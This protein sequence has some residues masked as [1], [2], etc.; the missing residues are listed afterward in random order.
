MARVFVTLTAASLVL[1][2]SYHFPQ[3]VPASAAE[4]KAEVRKDQGPVRF[5]PVL[6]GRTLRRMGFTWQQRKILYDALRDSSAGSEP[7]PLTRVHAIIKQA[8]TNHPTAAKILTELASR[9]WGIG[10]LKAYF[11]LAMKPADLEKLYSKVNGNLFGLAEHL[12]NAVSTRSPKA[13]TGK[14]NNLLSSFGTGQPVRLKNGQSEP[15]HLVAA[16]CLAMVLATEQCPSAGRGALALA[17]GATHQVRD[18]EARGILAELGLIDVVGNEE[19]QMHTGVM[20]VLRSCTAT[21]ESP[22]SYQSPVDRP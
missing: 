22:P 10:V 14:A 15:D 18:A 20:N 12:G 1:V 6:F 8:T 4:S 13:T 11:E 2:A 19:V 21:L 16:T 5:T 17:V 7:S 3:K 9:P